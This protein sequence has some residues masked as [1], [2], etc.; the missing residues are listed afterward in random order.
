MAKKNKSIELADKIIELID[1]QRSFEITSAIIKDDF[2][3]YSYDIT[4]GVGTGDSCKVT[5]SL[6]IHDDMIT[7]FQTFNRHL[8]A[9]DDV[10]IHSNIE[11]ENIDNMEN[12]EL[13]GLY[14]VHAFKVKGGEDN[15]SV[16]LSGMKYINSSGERIAIETP[17]IPLDALSSYRWY[18]ELLAAVN[19]AKS[20]VEQYKQGKG[21]PIEKDE[22]PNV[23]QMKIT[24][25]MDS[26]DVEDETFNAAKL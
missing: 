23:K 10:F 22:K 2:C 20:E 17:K 21:T 24:D 14:S 4:N 9:I 13:T 1:Q 12:S 8:A 11:V 19:A 6:I 25:D 3:N 26:V 7:A 15:M 5:G 16:V 18:N